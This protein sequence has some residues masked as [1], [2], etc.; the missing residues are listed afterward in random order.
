MPD[1]GPARKRNPAALPAVVSVPGS[2]PAGVAE[3]GHSVYRPRTGGAAVLHQAT[4]EGLARLAAA[5]TSL[6]ARSS[7]RSA[8]PRAAAP[9]PL[10]VC[11]DAPRGAFEPPPLAPL[12]TSATLVQLQ[13]PGLKL[14]CFYE[15]G[16]VVECGCCA[17]TR[18][19]LFKA[20]ASDA[21]RAS[22][23]LELIRKVFAIERAWARVSEDTERHLLTQAI[24]ATSTKHQCSHGRL[25][26]SHPVSRLLGFPPPA[27][28]P[29][30]ICASSLRR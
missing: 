20:L 2:P 16:D 28:I 8:P 3:A 18:R 22:Y 11:P 15:T 19:Y 24:V 17:H 14:L 30:S 10:G 6:P 13:D 12:A 25:I 5:G 9:S 7:A 23:A 27:A 21:P 4:P 1:V 26:F 29:S